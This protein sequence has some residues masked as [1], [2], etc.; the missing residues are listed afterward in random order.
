MNNNNSEQVNKEEEEREKR[1]IQ[2]EDEE[3]KRIEEEGEE[4]RKE[5]GKER[6]EAAY[7]GLLSG[8]RSVENFKRLNTVQEGTYGVVFRAQDKTNGEIVALKKVKMER[9]TEGFPITSLRE[10]S[11]LLT[12]KHPNIVN[13]KEIVVGSKTDSIFIVMEFLEHD[14]KD[15]MKEMKP[16][17]RF[18][19]SEVK[20]LM[21]QL[22]SA[23]AH[24]H[25]NWIIHRDLKTS[26]LLYNRK[27]ILKV[28]DFGLAREYGSPLKPYTPTVVTL[29][30]RAPEVLLG[31]KTYTPA[32]DIWSIGC[33]FAEFL[34]KQPLLPGRTELE[35]LD[36]IFSLLGT[37]NE[38]TW[39]GISSLPGG[40]RLNLNRT[41]VGNLRQHLG[42]PITEACED[43]LK[44][45]LTLDPEQRPTAAEALLHPYF[46]E[47]PRAKDPKAMP[48]WPS[49]HD[50][51]RKRRVSEGDDALR[52]KLLAAC[53]K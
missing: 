28:A 18:L 5:E 33:I 20:C 44:K 6:K 14:L 27:G 21:I 26:N 8:C 10:I 19:S 52:E 45:L 42:L 46:Q 16:E 43:L 35:Q 32:V 22:L 49:S 9:E 12:F 23:M 11:I 31:S 50:L 29:W 34:T 2:I 41:N 13:V 25:E 7:I 53:K 30:Y 37:P 17:Q 1:T 48:T 38:K 39:P 40:K 36:K 3:E 47:H 4:E 51:T 24:L 15:L